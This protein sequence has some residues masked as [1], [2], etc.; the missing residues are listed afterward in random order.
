MFKQKIKTLNNLIYHSILKN[1]ESKNKSNKF[2]SN[3]CLH[4]PEIFLMTELV[5]PAEKNYKLHTKFKMI[6]T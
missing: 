5:S 3:F 1:Q 4:D 6:M 2:F